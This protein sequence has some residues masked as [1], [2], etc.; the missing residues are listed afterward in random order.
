MLERIAADISGFVAQRD[1]VAMV[2][3]ATAATAPAFQ[4]V[5]NPIAESSSAGLFH[6]HDTPFRD[7]VSYVDEVAAW[8]QVTHDGFRVVQLQH[9]MPP[10]PETP[11]VVA[12]AGLPPVLRL[13]EL[14]TFSRSVLPDPANQVVVWT[15]L[16]SQIADPTGYARFFRELLAHEW[17]RPWC[18]HMRVMLRAEPGDEVMAKAFAAAPRVRWYE[19]PLGPDSYRKGY[20]D[21]VADATLPVPER[22]TALLVTAATDYSFGRDAQALEKY[23][24]LIQY[25]RA[26]G[27]SVPLALAWNGVGEVRAKGGDRVGAGAAFDVALAY[28][29]DGPAPQPAVLYTVAW[30]LGRLRMDEKRFGEAADCFGIAQQSAAC[31]R[32]AEIKLTAM[33]W[34]GV[35]RA[36]N[37]EPEKAVELWEAGATVAHRLKLPDHREAMLARLR[38]HFADQPDRVRKFERRLAETP[39]ASA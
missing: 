7:P 24:L 13:R 27:E 32:A 20:E 10:W 35:A 16:P 36:A 23:E 26:R 18:H 11:P 12:E 34:Q 5:L 4:E 28:A 15:F 9:G 37:R 31:M 38:D 19:P 2:V 22:M 21:A 14:M 33:E 8:F 25:H 17:P 6:T 1:D 30:N 29:A 3:R 39:P